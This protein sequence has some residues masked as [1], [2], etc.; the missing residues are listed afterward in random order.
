M[1]LDSVERHTF[2]AR[3]ECHYLL[4]TPASI[5]D[6]TLLVLTLHGYGSNPE[7]M[8][9]LTR[10]MLGPNHVIASIQ[11][12]SQFFPSN[13]PDGTVGYCWTS[14]AHPKSSVRLHHEMLLHVAGEVGSRLGIGAGRRLLIGFSQPV[15]LNY[16]FA[17]TYPGEV[18]GVIG[19][20]GG[21]P[22]NWED[23]EYERVS[24]GLLHIARREDEIFPPAVT[25]KYADR[26]RLHADDVEFHLL[27]GGHKFPSKANSIVERWIG[28]VFYV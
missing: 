12:P 13:A 18:R 16:R 23:G 4:H 14:P 10:T 7:V 25:G 2:E 26:L 8:L 6:R 24:A 3:L 28:R 5:E 15:G 19:I 1:V 21:M 9:R 27:D 20:C 17:A 11:A 22:K